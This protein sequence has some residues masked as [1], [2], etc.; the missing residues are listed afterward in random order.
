MSVASQIND[1]PSEIK[2]NRVPLA[3]NKVNASIN[4]KPMYSK[5]RN[6]GNK[7]KMS[8]SLQ[9]LTQVEIKL[10]VCLNS[11]NDGGELNTCLL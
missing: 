7:K 1:L 4:R 6:T 10:P 8:Q 2:L 3:Q 11:I 9:R 5:S